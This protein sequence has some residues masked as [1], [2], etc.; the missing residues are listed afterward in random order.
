MKNAELQI[1]ASEMLIM[2]FVILEIFFTRC[3]KAEIEKGVSPKRLE[4][5]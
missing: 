3:G 1:P 4:T 2:I 5:L